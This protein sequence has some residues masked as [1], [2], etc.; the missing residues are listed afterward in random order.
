MRALVDVY[1]MSRL[2]HWLWRA[3]WIFVGIMALFAAAGA[4][5]GW[6]DTWETLVGRRSPK[7]AAYPYLSWPLSVIGWVA[8]P[9]LVGAVIGYLMT[10]QANRRRTRSVSEAA[11]QVPFMPRR[12]V[13]QRGVPHW[14]ERTLDVVARGPHRN[15]FVLPFV[16]LHGYDFDWADQCWRACVNTLLEE[17]TAAESIEPPFRR[18]WAEE[19][20]VQILVD[21]ANSNPPYCMSCGPRSPQGPL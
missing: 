3:K 8:L 18:T 14:Y 9:A 16:A 1:A 10:A 19:E 6:S 21:A 4:V 13:A 17:A 2:R 7:N 11:A 15:S 5:M 20:A 12:R